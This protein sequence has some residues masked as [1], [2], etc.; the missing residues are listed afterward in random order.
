ML[1][2]ASLHRWSMFYGWLQPALY[3]LTEER[4]LIEAVLAP[5]IAYSAMVPPRREEFFVRGLAAG[6]RGDFLVAECLLVPQIENSLRW[7]LHK[8]RPWRC[9]PK[10]G[11][12]APGAGCRTAPC[13]SRTAR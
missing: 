10:R 6:F 1:R 9:Q 4:S 8:C 2:N 7:V 13:Q 11:I 5:V 12:R 3:K